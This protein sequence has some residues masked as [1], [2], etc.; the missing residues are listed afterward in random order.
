MP[1]SCPLLA[2]WYEVNTILLDPSPPISCFLEF[3]QRGAF[4][5]VI[6]LSSEYWAHCLFSIGDSENICISVHLYTPHRL[7][8]VAFDDYNQNNK[9]KHR[10]DPEH[11]YN[12]NCT[13]RTYSIIQPLICFALLFWRKVAMVIVLAASHGVGQALKVMS[14]NNYIC[15]A[16]ASPILYCWD[17]LNTPLVSSFRSFKETQ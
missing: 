14:H 8:L 11:T 3:N 17:V 10:A 9:C 1:L 2:D 16:S 5:G 6:G 13:Q 7:S 4:W 15:L 12:S